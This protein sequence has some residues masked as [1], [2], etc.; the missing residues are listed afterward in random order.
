MVAYNRAQQTEV[1]GNPR[2][3]VR[4]GARWL[5][6]SEQRIYQLA[7]SGELPHFRLGRRIYFSPEV[8]EVQS[9][10]ITSRFVDER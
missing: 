9:G 2:V 1:P 4:W 6:V 3:G 10:W 8:L 5:G 7:R